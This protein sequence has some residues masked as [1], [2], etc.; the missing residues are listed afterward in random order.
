MAYRIST[1]STLSRLRP[2]HVDV[3]VCLQEAAVCELRQRRA[4]ADE[5]SQG[6]RWAM[7]NAHG[8][9]RDSTGRGAGRAER[10][11]GSVTLGSSR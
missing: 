9:W 10:E 8:T 6:S 3:R 5:A 2:M 7:S 4:E 11:S 1:Q